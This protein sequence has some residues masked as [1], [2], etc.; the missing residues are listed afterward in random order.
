M[1]RRIYF[2]LGGIALVSFYYLSASFFHQQLSCSLFTDSPSCSH[3]FLATLYTPLYVIARTGP[4]GLMAMLLIGWVVGLIAN[5][6]IP[7]SQPATAVPEVQVPKK[8]TF[9]AL[10]ITLIVIGIIAWQY[11][12][13]VTH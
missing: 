11:Y 7:G 10:I 12:Y 2:Q 13:M 3:P 4:I 6:I 9:I 5:K 1:K 8:Y